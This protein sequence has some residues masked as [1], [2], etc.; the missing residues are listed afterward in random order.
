MK[1]RNRVENKVNFVSVAAFAVC[2]LYFKLAQYLKIMYI[3]SLKG[4]S[5]N[6]PLANPPEGAAVAWKKCFS[7]FNAKFPTKILAKHAP[8]FYF[9]L[10]LFKTQVFILSYQMPSFSP[11]IKQGP[12]I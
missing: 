10:Q 1:W 2:K 3:H 12:I 6:K 7:Q 11:I 4:T 5:L 9:L 8:S